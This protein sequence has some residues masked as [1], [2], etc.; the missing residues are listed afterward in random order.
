MF[1]KVLL[2]HWTDL[3]SNWTTSTTWYCCW[4][5]M[6]WMRIC[7][8]DYSCLASSLVSSLWPTMSE[9]ATVRR[10]EEWLVQNARDSLPHRTEPP[11]EMEDGHTS[12]LPSSSQSPFSFHLSHPV[13]SLPHI[14]CLVRAD[15][16]VAE[17]QRPAQPT[18]YCSDYY[19]RQY[20][21]RR[22]CCFR[23][24]HHRSPLL[25]LRCRCCCS[26]GC[27]PPPYEVTPPLFGTFYARPPIFMCTSTTNAFSHW[28][29]W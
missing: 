23:S 24:V 29:I 14:D 20:I 6:H 2:K 8:N 11:P 16:S 27:H 5:A 18:H 4:C 7:A 15:P 1:R 3:F 19:C 28:P 26:F 13:P 17:Q 25:P 22:V 9:Y 12:T 10:P 21:P